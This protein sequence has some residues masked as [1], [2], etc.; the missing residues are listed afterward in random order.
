ML[1]YFGYWL[2]QAGSFYQPRRSKFG[3]F[4]LSLFG[5]LS[6]SVDDVISIGGGEGLSDEDLG[7]EDSDEGGDAPMVLDPDFESV[8]N[9]LLSYDAL[10]DGLTV[11]YP[12]GR[13]PVEDPLRGFSTLDTFVSVTPSRHSLTSVQH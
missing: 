1:P 2:C 8:F 3:L 11:G 9:F 7:D 10:T 12:L 6:V 13:R 5:D 4:S